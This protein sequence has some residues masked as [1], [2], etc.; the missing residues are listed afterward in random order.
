MTP[1]W[2]VQPARQQYVVHTY[3]LIPHTANFLPCLDSDSIAPW[4]ELIT[5][6]SSNVTAGVGKV[7]IGALIKYHACSLKCDVLPVVTTYLS[8]LHNSRGI[9][10]A[11]SS[12]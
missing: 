9:V 4:P 11:R 2:F 12:L 10:G 3:R 8:C 5:A 7:A 1:I 6:T